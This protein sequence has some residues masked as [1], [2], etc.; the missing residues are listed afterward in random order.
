MVS[1]RNR[2]APLRHRVARVQYDGS[3]ADEIKLC[4]IHPFRLPRTVKAHIDR[5]IEAYVPRHERTRVHKDAYFGGIDRALTPPLEAP[6]LVGPIFR[7]Q[8]QR[9]F[10]QAQSPLFQL[11]AEIRVMIWRQAIGGYFIRIACDEGWDDGCGGAEKWWLFNLPLA[12]RRI[13]HETIDLLY[14]TNILRLED[15][16][17]TQDLNNWKV[18]PHRLECITAVILA[19]QRLYPPER[20]SELE[21]LNGRWEAL[22][23]FPKLQYLRIEI[24]FWRGGE[25]VFPHLD[26]LFDPFVRMTT[27]KHFHLIVSYRVTDVGEALKRKFRDTHCKLGLISVGYLRRP[28]PRM[29]TDPFRVWPLREKWIRDDPRPFGSEQCNMLEQRDWLETVSERLRNGQM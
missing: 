13:Y 28:S 25:K 5:K 11:P 7:K 17:W 24:A 15:Y 22:Q 1:L 6:V 12:C 8:R 16:S 9:T 23:Q 27:P 3:R 20:K 14:S 10:D 29:V 2:N 21:F 26:D 18:L 4:I 19:G